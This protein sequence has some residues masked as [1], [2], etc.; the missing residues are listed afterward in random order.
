MN[1]AA[2]VLAAGGSSRLGQPKQLLALG[3]ESFV[4]RT[5][6]AAV[7]AGCAPVIVVLGAEAERIQEETDSLP[8]TVVQNANWTEGIGSSIRVGLLHVVHS[9]ATID[10]ALLLACDQPFVDAGFLKELIQ[11]R[12]TSAKSIVASAYAG[13][14][15][16]PALFDRTLFPEL[17]ASSGDQ[18]AK[19]II[20][21]R[22]QETA[23]LSFPAGAI[24]I[25]TPDDLKRL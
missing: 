12:L 23:S 14:L 25:D 15:G 24:D 3:G 6:R 20:L 7:E 11:L 16:V 22:P 17:L 9:R 10:A 1:I 5:I 19:Q 18:G 8:A 13:T 21:S 2:I 4:R